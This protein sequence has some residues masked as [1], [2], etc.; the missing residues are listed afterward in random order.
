M[1]H[2]EPAPHACCQVLEL[3]QYTLHPGGREPLAALFEQHFLDALEETGMHVPGL[4]ADVDDPDRL[5]WLRGFPNQAARHRALTDF[6]LTGSVWRE[7]S[8]AANATMVDSDDVLLLR[9]AYVGPR[10]PH[11]SAPRLTR[12]DAAPG[13]L[14]VDVVDLGRI[15]RAPWSGSTWVDDLVGLAQAA[16]AEVLLVAATHPEP[17]DFPGLPVRDERVG[18]W[19]VRYP[20]AATRDRLRK[21]L[22][23]GDADEQ[24]HLTALPGSQIG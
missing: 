2:P 7:H 8:A 11:R 16:G 1:S 4:F 24:V 15:E 14:V 9:P 10:Y 19:L 6:Y 13:S 22:G 3:R 23:L 21:T 17:N 18:V 12:P 5:V 20:D